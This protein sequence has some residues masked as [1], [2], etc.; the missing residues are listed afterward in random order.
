MSFALRRE[1]NRSW[2]PDA[3]TVMATLQLRALPDNSNGYL[4]TTEH[5]PSWSCSSLH[6]L[7][8]QHLSDV[9]NMKSTISLVMYRRVRMWLIPLNVLLKRKNFFRN[10]N[11]EAMVRIIWNP[12]CSFL[13]LHVVWN[14]SGKNDNSTL[15]VVLRAKIS[16]FFSLTMPQPFTVPLIFS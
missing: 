1:T 5:P 11:T 9:P 16:V 15:P 8:S 3:H 12:Q 7:V 2:T 13:A 10:T 6:I 14:V 4:W